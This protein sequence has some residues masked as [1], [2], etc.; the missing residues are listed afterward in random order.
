MAKRYNARKDFTESIEKMNFNVEEYRKLAPLCKQLV[1][2]YENQLQSNYFGSIDHIY[3]CMH[4]KGEIPEDF[5]CTCENL[6]LAGRPD[7]HSY[8]S[9]GKYAYVELAKGTHFV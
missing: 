8:I 4:F 9:S 3:F 5:F 7:S 1:E 6:K 2:K